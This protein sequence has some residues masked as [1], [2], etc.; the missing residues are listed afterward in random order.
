MNKYHGDHSLYLPRS[1]NL[2]FELSTQHLADQSVESTPVTIND[3]NDNLPVHCINHSDYAIVIPKHSYVRAME[4]VQESNQNTLPTN[5]SLEPVSKRALSKCLAHSD[6]LPSQRQSIHTLLLNF[7]KLTKSKADFETNIVKTGLTL[8][9][10]NTH[11][12]PSSNS[13]IIIERTTDLWHHSSLKDQVA[14]R[15]TRED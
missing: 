7:L 4:K 11:Y 3:K 1:R 8:S 14:S 9:P 2:L 6:L 15:K 12:M 13:T 5:T 10:A